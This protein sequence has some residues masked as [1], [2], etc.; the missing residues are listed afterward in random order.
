MAF[1]IVALILPLLAYI[2]HEQL[3]RLKKSSDV[4]AHKKDYVKIRKP[5]IKFCYN[6]AIEDCSSEYDIS[7]TSNKL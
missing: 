5:L 7:S 4:T 1:T 2:Y 3:T 6:Y